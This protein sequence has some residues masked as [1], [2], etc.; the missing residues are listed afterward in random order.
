MLNIFKSE[1]S[2]NNNSIISQNFFF[3]T[4]TKTRCLNCKI[5]KYNYQVL[6]LLEFPLELIFNFCLTNNIPCI[7]NKNNKYILLK[8]CFKQYS[9]PSQFI[10]D[11]QL[12]CNK[13]N[14]LTNAL[15][16][17]R[18]YSLPKTSDIITIIE[19]DND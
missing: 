2:K 12:Y 13:C 3:I 6:Y 1:F 9:F 10:G 15:C 5:L 14:K 18:L 19:S 7:D 11:N 8:N 16:Q 4:E 17:S